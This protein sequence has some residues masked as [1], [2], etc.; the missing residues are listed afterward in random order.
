MSDSI[1]ARTLPLAGSLRRPLIWLLAITGLA[2][3]G[4]AV[5]LTLTLAHTPPA[6]APPPY[7]VYLV[8]GVVL[9]G[10][11]LLA[12]MIA[13]ASVSVDQGELVLNT[14]MGTKHI[15]LSALRKHGLQL[16]NLN[17]RLQLK[18]SRR[19]WGAGLPGFSGGWFRLRNGEKAVCI[20]LDRDH[21]CHLRSDED[22]LTV[23]LSLQQP[24]KL[25]ALLER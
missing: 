25:R 24:E 23:L 4:V 20:V 3:A 1:D 11:L 21:V 9:L 18:P 12:R 10:Q 8:L 17:E 2:F 7:F 15:R 16:V 13:R 14:G 6:K 5:V 22:D 19:T